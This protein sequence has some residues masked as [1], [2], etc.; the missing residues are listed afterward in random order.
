M[1]AQQS[2]EAE[3]R[4]LPAFVHSGRERLEDDNYQTVDPRCAQALREAWPVP[5]PC[6]DP[7]APSGSGLAA[8]WPGA[9]VCTGD[10]LNDP[11][12]DGVSS[13]VFN[14]PYVRPLVDQIVWRMRDLVLSGDLVLAAALLRPQWDYAPGDP[15][16]PTPLRAELFDRP[17]FAGKVQLRFRPWWSD[18]RS[19]GGIHHSQWIIFDRRHRAEPVVRYW[20]VRPAGGAS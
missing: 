15:K 16:G 4:K 5:T 10:A 17:P 1:S 9:F 3:E 14:P 11:V 12:P 7:C 18:Q 19:T 6:W 13:A 8:G 20:P 2:F